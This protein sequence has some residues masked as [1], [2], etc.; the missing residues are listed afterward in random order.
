[1]EQLEVVEIKRNSKG[2]LT[3]FILNNGQELSY[4]EAF[5]MAENGQIKSADQLQQN[6]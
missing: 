2:E 5:I 1:M 6:E 3:N 4:R